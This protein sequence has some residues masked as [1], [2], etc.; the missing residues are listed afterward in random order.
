[1]APWTTMSFWWP[2]E[3]RGTTLEKVLDRRIANLDNEEFYSKKSLILRSNGT[4]VLYE[5]GEEIKG[6]V[7][8]RKEQF[9]DGNWELI[10]AGTDQSTIKVFGKYVS[11][12]ELFDYYKGSSNK[13]D[14]TNKIFKDNLV[15]DNKS[16]SGGKIMSRF[17]FE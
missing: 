15:I 7:G 6:S 17:L 9:A 13:K 1:M 12:S 14:N 16:I 8:S 4:F 2:S 5:E 3:E 10:N 11:L